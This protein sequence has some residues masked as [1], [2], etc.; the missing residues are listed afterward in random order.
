M[1]LKAVWRAIPAVALILRVQMF[2]LLVSIQPEIL[3]QLQ[4]ELENI[5]LTPRV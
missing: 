2:S 1:N 3:K 4:L 5:G